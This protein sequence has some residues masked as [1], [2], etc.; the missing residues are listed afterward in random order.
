MFVTEFQT[1]IE[2]KILVKM[3]SYSGGV[4]M[5]QDTTLKKQNKIEYMFRTPCI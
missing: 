3:Q 4:G 5:M 1:H 2:T